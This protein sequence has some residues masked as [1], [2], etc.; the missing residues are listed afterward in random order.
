MMSRNNQK[1]PDKLYLVRHGESVRNKAKQ[2]SKKN[3]ELIHWAEGLGRDQDTKLTE[4]GVNQANHTAAY[5]V[6]QTIT[7]SAKDVIVIVSPFSRA[8]QTSEPFIE[9]LKKKS[10]EDPQV[11]VE[12]RIREVEF[13]I[14]DGL[15]AAGIRK[16]YPLEWERKHKEGK[17][18]YRPPGGENRPDVRMRL[19]SFNSTLTREFAGKV[20][21]AYAHSEVVWLERSLL[22]RWNEEK[23]ITMGKEYEV[24]NCSVTQYSCNSLGRLELTQFNYCP[25][26]PLEGGQGEVA[27]D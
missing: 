11:F 6:Q 12:E 13:G 16:I 27:H 23:Y 14:L 25:W 19:R 9:L 2:T 3:K 4:E 15:T 17:Y 26:K 5:L 1:W 24:D 21:V 18:Y 7:R 22:E 10:L 8:I 20:V